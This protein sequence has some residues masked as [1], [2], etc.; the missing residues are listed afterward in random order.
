VRRRR[1]GELTERQTQVIEQVF[2]NEIHAIL[3]PMAVTCPADFPLLP[4]E[5]STSAYARS[6]PRRTRPP[7]F[8]VTPSAGTVSRVITLP[9]TA[10]T[11][12][13]LKTSSAYSSNVLPR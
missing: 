6:P 9:P 12:L 5:R 3:T 10:A 1:P 13:A 7:R 11:I 4:A 2:D 8:A